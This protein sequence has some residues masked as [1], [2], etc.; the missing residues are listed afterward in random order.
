MAGTHFLYPWSLGNNRQTVTGSFNDLHAG[1]IETV[2]LGTNFRRVRDGDWLWFTFTGTDRG[3]VAVAV[4][5]GEPFQAS[6]TSRKWEIE[7]E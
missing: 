1:K 5:V 6:G 7:V 4:A 3:I 2:F